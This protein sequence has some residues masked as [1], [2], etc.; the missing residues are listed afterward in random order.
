MLQFPVLRPVSP[1]SGVPPGQVDFVLGMANMP[2]M[3][4]IAIRVDSLSKPY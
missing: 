4:E 2:T 1:I 3:I